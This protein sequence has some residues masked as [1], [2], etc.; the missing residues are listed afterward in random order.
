VPF[1]QS[2]GAALQGPLKNLMS[3][4]T[5]V[6][7]TLG[8]LLTVTVAQLSGPLAKAIS[9]IA[10]ALVPALGALTGLATPIGGLVNLIGKI[11]L[12]LSPIVQAILPPLLAGINTVAQG[13]A[14]VLPALGVALGKLLTALSPLIPIFAQLLATAGAQLIGALTQLA[15]ILTP[16]ANAATPVAKALGD[17]VN[18]LLKI[19]GLGS[20]VGMLGVLL[21]IFGKGFPSSIGTAVKNV[22][23]FTK[24]FQS[25]G[26]E[27]GLA[28][29]GIAAKVGG[30]GGKLLTAAKSVGGV[31]SAFSAWGAVAGLA[32]TG[33]SLGI[34]ALVGWLHRGQD[35]AKAMAQQTADSFEQAAQQL[36]G[37]DLQKQIDLT[38]AKIKDI[39]YQQKQLVLQGQT[40]NLGIPYDDLTKALDGSKQGLIN[41]F[42][43][44]KETLAKSGDSS[45]KISM[46]TVQQNKVVTDAIAGNWSKVA[47][48]LGGAGKQNAQ[49]ISDL[50]AKLGGKDGLVATLAAQKDAQDKADEAMGYTAGQT[51][52]QLARSYGQLQNAQS[53]WNQNLDD[54]ANKLDALLTKQLDAQ[55]ANDSYIGGLNNLTTQFQ[56]NKDALAGNID[57][58]KGLLTSVTANTQILP[59]MTTAQVA[60]ANATLSQKQ[61]LD[62]AI[63]SG[64]QNIQ[65]LINQHKPTTDITKATN[66]FYNQLVN[67]ANQYGYTQDA[68]KIYLGQL[69]QTPQ[70]VATDISTSGYDT[71]L[72]QLAVIAAE[73]KDIQTGNVTVTPNG[74][75]FFGS[76]VAANVTQGA[77]AAAAL[78]IGA[79]ASLGT[80]SPL[81]VPG[82]ATGGMITSGPHLVGE[83]NRHYP[84]YVIPTDPAYAGTARSLIAAV[85]PKIK[86][87]QGG[88]ILQWT[89][90]PPTTSQPTFGPQ[91]GTTAQVPLWSAQLGIFLANLGTNALN[92]TLPP[93]IA[94]MKAR[95]QQELAASASATGSSAQWAALGQALA[96]Q[97]YGWTGP[98]WVALNNVAMRESG[99]NPTAQN[100]TSSAYG[101][102]QNIGGPGGYPDPSPRGQIMWMLNYIKNRYTDPIGAWNHELSAGWYDKG[103]YLPPG[104]SL[105]LNQT[106]RPEYVVPMQ[107]GGTIPSSVTGNT[108]NIY[109]GDTAGTLSSSSLDAI[110]GRL[111]SWFGAG[112]LSD[113]ATPINATAA[114]GQKLAAKKHWSGMQWTALQNLVEAGSRWDTHS[115]YT[116][117]DNKIQQLETV[118]WEKR[119]A[120]LLR[121]HNAMVLA[122]ENYHKAHPK[123]ALHL[124]PMPHIPAPPYYLPNHP[125]GL[126]EGIHGLYNSHWY[127]AWGGNATTMDGQ[128][129]AVLNYIARAYGSP[130]AAWAHQMATGWYDA[131]GYLPPGVSIAI[132]NTGKPEQVIPHGQGTHGAPTLHIENM[133]VSD[134]TDV[135]MMLNQLD[136]HYQRGG[137]G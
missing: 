5:S 104:L 105:A 127:Q 77:A 40:D 33:V 117:A 27:G 135:N 101:I 36:A 57:M 130:T 22:G 129:N 74:T 1:I 62:Q 116:A 96:A 17:V 48:D 54:S 39:Q 23:G 122:A 132:N 61:A 111:E 31:A 102:A 114:E 12:G 59:T 63:A 123:T 32:V 7:Q 128:I 126:G 71:A 2:L 35:A 84:E 79:A 49:V 118:A 68:M 51:I 89:G 90:Q 120:T 78:G 95:V 29:E 119:R 30:M 38:T 80:G 103:G 46:E 106:G 94:A 110:L 107:T 6:F 136:F 67:N 93:L 137:W 14:P 85:T 18:V 112:L 3:G 76:Q 56:Q 124:P 81:G 131:G 16:L 43:N 72:N 125:F 73:I 121:Q 70:D 88:G 19:P 45:T 98:E 15:N 115:G 60:A 55:N 26:Q 69:Q 20:T 53:T 25:V 65:S 133:T 21:G 64:D 83:G 113:V 24:A 66:D 109:L 9:D 58:Q 8:P 41:W 82:H 10:Q 52:P 100:P 34:S 42:N 50:Q 87:Y 134:Q 11:A 108:L 37:G 91:V 86:G 99:W 47:A 28:M 97:L 13:L 92:V 44:Y 4:L 75:V